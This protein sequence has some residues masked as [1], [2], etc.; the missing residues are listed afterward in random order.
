MVLSSKVSLIGFLLLLLFVIGSFQNEIFSREISITNTKVEKWG[1]GCRY[2]V[3]RRNHTVKNPVLNVHINLLTKQGTADH[4]DWEDDTLISENPRIDYLISKFCPSYIE[5]NGVE[6]LE[7]ILN[8][9][10]EVI[11]KKTIEV[12]R[13]Y[14]SSPSR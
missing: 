6:S 9:G 7:Y 14:S 11:A 4:F 13:D 2:T 12:S 5:K 1:D 10:S 3:V 8:N